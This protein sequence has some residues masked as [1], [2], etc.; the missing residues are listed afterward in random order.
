MHFLLALSLLN[1]TLTPAPQ[2]QA[3]RSPLVGSDQG[4]KTF[5]AAFAP[6]GGRLR[7]IEVN[8][9]PRFGGR[10]VKGLR[11]IAEDAD[12]RSLE[13]VVGPATGKYEAPIVLG[14]G[15]EVVGLSGKHGRVVDSI[16]FHLSDGSATP[17]FGGEGG[18]DDFR[19]ILKLKKG[20]PLGRVTGLFGAADDD[21]ITALGLLMTDR[22]GM[23]PRLDGP[24]P[25]VLI[26]RGEVDAAFAPTVGRLTTLFYEGY[27]KLLERFD[28]PERPASREITLV[29]KRG[30]DVPAYCRGAEVSINIDWLKRHP[31]DVALLTHELTH[32]VQRYP[33]Q[34]VGWL[35]EG[36][37][38]YARF[39]YGPKDQPGWA[40]PA[41]LTAKQSYKDSYRTTARFLVWLEEKHPGIVDKIHRRLRSGTF[42][43][44][45]F[46]EFTGRGVD[47]LWADCVAEPK[48][49]P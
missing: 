12:G 13:T 35:V 18:S 45:A 10:V 17:T 4:K 25:L 1:L 37:A 3:V 32:A 40:L 20:A 19:L 23:A 29:F 9:G 38:D 21:S 14:Q 24:E 46:Q 36:I 31:D 8:V 48:D 6:E 49:V 34:R 44:H 15:V 16:Q 43:I 33:A 7:S 22:S 41:K 5:D 39:A 47:D 42:H 27:P 2:E 28:D 30:M 26:T 11:L